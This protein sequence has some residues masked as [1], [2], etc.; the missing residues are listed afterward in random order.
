MLW[1]R[2]QTVPPAA[3]WRLSRLATSWLFITSKMLQ[4]RRATRQLFPCDVDRPA[5]WDERRGGGGGGPVACQ[6]HEVVS[7][8]RRELRIMPA[9]RSLGGRVAQR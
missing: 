1:G 6:H 4:T 9:A 3:K 2:S 8:H 5:G 7:A